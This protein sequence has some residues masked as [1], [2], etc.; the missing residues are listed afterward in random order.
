MTRPSALPCSCALP[1]SLQIHMEVL[2]SPREG[3]ES[4]GLDP[5]G[6]ELP[7]ASPWGCRQH[8]PPAL[9]PEFLPS[10]Q[11]LCWLSLK[12]MTLS[13]RPGSGS[14]DIPNENQI[15]DSDGQV[16]LGTRVLGTRAMS[17]SL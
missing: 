7:V 3:D 14:L 9:K 5:A 1:S 10:S 13:R 12:P 17:P 6:A 15:E 8:Q 4:A 11:V 16:G 2:G